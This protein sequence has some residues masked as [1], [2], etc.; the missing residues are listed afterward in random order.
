MIR[1]STL[2]WDFVHHPIATLGIFLPCKKT[3]TNNIHSGVVF[4]RSDAQTIKVKLSH[5][6]ICQP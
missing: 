1:G 3:S 6:R 5:L 2:V 4:R